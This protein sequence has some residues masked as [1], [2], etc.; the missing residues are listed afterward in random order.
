[1][2][3]PNIAKLRHS[4]IRAKI[5]TV[6]RILMGMKPEVKKLEAAFQLYGF[7][8]MNDNLGDRLVRACVEN[9]ISLYDLN[10]VK[11]ISSEKIPWPNGFFSDN[12]QIMYLSNNARKRAEKILDKLKKEFLIAQNSSQRR[13]F[14][15]DMYKCEKRS[16]KTYG[17]IKALE[18]KSMLKD[19]KRALKDGY[20]INSVTFYRL[21]FSLCNAKNLEECYRLFGYFPLKDNFCD[22]VVCTCAAGDH[23]N[24]FINAVCDNTDCTY[25][26]A[27][28]IFWYFLEI[29]II[30]HHFSRD[31]YHSANPGRAFV[32]EETWKRY[33]KGEF[34]D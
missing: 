13:K 14:I 30:K 25:N 6:W 17:S 26:E 23:M 4:G 28:E 34:N 31:I 29:L 32:R 9:K 7:S 22:R 12:I 1:M 10:L 19:L 5:P 24:K 8:F 20:S 11:S 3:Y 18:D 2:S 27:A 15:H 33:E 21:A 16:S